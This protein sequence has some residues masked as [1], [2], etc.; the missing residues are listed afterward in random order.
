MGSCVCVQ[1]VLCMFTVG[2]AAKQKKWLA[3]AGRVNM[4]SLLPLLQLT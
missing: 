3:L 4:R 1:L 2:F